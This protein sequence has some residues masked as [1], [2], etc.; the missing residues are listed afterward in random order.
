MRRRLLI[1]DRNNL[2]MVGEV[3]SQFLKNEL[4]AFAGLQSQDKL[5]RVIWGLH[6][7]K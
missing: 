2:Q 1:M 5:S 4:V 6:T 3:S 7:Q